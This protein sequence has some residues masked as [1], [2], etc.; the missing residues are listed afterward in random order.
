MIS[1]NSSMIIKKHGVPLRDQIEEV[2]DENMVTENGYG[3]KFE[4]ND[5][6]GG[7]IM[8]EEMKDE[9]ATV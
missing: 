2:K 3:D 5:F 1:D 9:Q 7:N 8:E 4:F 6:F